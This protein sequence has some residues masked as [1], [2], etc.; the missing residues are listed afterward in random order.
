MNKP[1][2]IYL[3]TKKQKAE[4][5]QKDMARSTKHLEKEPCVIA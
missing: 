5:N 3:Q 1:L 2:I 4:R